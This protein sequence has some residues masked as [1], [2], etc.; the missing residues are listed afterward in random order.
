MCPF[1]KYL[2]HIF[3][4]IITYNQ[5]LYSLYTYFKRLSVVAGTFTGICGSE[6]DQVTEKLKSE[7]YVFNIAILKSETFFIEYL[8]EPT[9]RYSLR[10]RVICRKPPAKYEEIFGMFADEEI[11]HLPVNT[12]SLIFVNSWRCVWLIFE[13]V[14]WRLEIYRE[15]ICWKCGS[16]CS[17]AIYNRWYCSISQSITCRQHFSLHYHYC[18]N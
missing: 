2:R 11:I 5:H 9:D 3:A 10:E 15:W 13:Q 4:T 16:D 17:Q 8:Y 7:S 6:E 12:M 14:E 1:V 18:S